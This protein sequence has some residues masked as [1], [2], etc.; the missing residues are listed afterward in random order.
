M[1]AARKCL[2]DSDEFRVS[3]TTFSLQQNC[4]ELENR[5][6]PIIYCRQ[7]KFIKVFLL[8]LKQNKNYLEYK[9]TPS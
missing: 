9:L 7:F 5:I 6:F 2:F 8:V 3:P 1:R 4:G